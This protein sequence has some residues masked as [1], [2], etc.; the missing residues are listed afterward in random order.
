MN[1]LI[2]AA[3]PLLVLSAALSACAVRLGGGGPQQYSAVALQAAAGASAEQVGD[4]LR[5]AGADVVLLSADGDSAWFAGV[6]ASSG[7]ELSGPGRT[8]DR[9]LGF[10]TNLE[11]LGDT[12]MVLGVEG[13]GAVHMHD[14]LYRVSGERYLNLMLVHFD[15]P[16]LRAAVRTLLLYVANDVMA[17]AA[18]LLAIDG[19]TPAVADSAAV[20]MRAHYTPAVECA[21]D[22]GE[23]AATGSLRLLYGPVARLTCRSARLLPGS[24]AGIH[25]EVVVER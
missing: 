22:A 9:G 10:L 18:V 1:R 25:A 21:D 6:A 2:R 11:V 20:L 17:N 19:A 12:S 16:D 3:L 15:A 13:G 8:S 7:L 5:T 24:P 4:R 14:A 23:V